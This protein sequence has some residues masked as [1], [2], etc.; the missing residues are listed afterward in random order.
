MIEKIKQIHKICV[1]LCFGRI[2]T[3]N[4]EKKITMLAIISSI[5]SAGQSIK[6]RGIVCPSHYHFAEL[7]TSHSSGLMRNLFYYYFFSPTHEMCV[8]NS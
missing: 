7:S 6:Y 1:Y 2:N 4:K 3:Y 5:M 8:N